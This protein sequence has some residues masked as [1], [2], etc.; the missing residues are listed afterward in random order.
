MLLAYLVVGWSLS[1]HHKHIPSLQERQLRLVH[2]PMVHVP[3]APPLS[4]R[5]RRFR[6]EHDMVYHK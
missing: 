2:A 5:E 4:D 6:I 3:S 1:R